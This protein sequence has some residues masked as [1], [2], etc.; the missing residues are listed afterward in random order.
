[1]KIA[2]SENHQERWQKFLRTTGRGAIIIGLYGLMQAIVNATMSRDF[3]SFSPIEIEIET[4]SN[5]LYLVLRA[6][7]FS[8]FAISGIAILNR[9]FWVRPLFAINAILF[10]PL[11]IL[12]A[13]GFPESFNYWLTPFPWILFLINIGFLCCFIRKDWATQPLGGGTS[14]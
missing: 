11:I 8:L 9:S 7:Y 2:K 3:P 6:T 4:K 5:T 10:I 14:E 1:M 12:Y 13:E